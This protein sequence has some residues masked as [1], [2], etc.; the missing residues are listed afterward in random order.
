MGRGLRIR[1]TGKLILLLRLLREIPDKVERDL[2]RFCH[3]RYSDRWR[4][5]AAGTPLLTL[6]EIWVLICDLPGSAAIVA[7]ENGGVPRWGTVEHLLADIWGALAGQPHPGRPKSRAKQ[8]ITAARR[9]AT[10]RV[11]DR[12]AKRN[13]LMG[14]AE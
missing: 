1:R 9:R 2:R 3:V 14:N 5:D 10:Q 6:R 8:A 4:Y 11:K 12:F 7:H 13:R